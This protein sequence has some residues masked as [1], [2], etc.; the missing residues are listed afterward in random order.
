MKAPLVVT[1][2]TEIIKIVGTRV[3]MVTVLTVLLR[4]LR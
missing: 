1:T 3:E 4:K 2:A